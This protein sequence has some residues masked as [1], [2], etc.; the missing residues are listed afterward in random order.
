LRRWQ[1]EWESLA[2]EVQLDHRPWWQST[3]AMEGKHNAQKAGVENRDAGRQ[4]QSRA[5][6]CSHG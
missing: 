4:L 1:A 2:T 5:A 3:G 6:C